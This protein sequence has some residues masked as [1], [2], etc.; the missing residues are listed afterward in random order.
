MA[1]QKTA[2]DFIHD[3]LKEAN[4]TE[5]SVNVNWVVKMIERRDKENATEK[6]LNEI[7]EQISQLVDEWHKL[8]KL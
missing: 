7:R 3:E 5:L 4:Y 8:L 1:K 6:R 2:Y